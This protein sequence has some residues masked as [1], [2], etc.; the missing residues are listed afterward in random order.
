MNNDK[1]NGNDN[2]K[3]IRLR[4]LSRTSSSSTFPR[5]SPLL[6][7]PPLRQDTLSLTS[8]STLIGNSK[9]IFQEPYL[10]YFGTLEVLM[11]EDLKGPLFSQT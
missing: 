5:V 2:D 10:Y 8:T 6:T 4:S 11:F 9:S 1:G 3:T 7:P